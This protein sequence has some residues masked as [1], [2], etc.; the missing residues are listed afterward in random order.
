MD[1]DFCEGLEDYERG[2]YN[3]FVHFPERLSLEELKVELMS[4][5]IFCELLIN[6]IEQ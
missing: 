6:D 1:S 3:A 4:Q 2:V 5:S